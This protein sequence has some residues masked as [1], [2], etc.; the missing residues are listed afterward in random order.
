MTW[1][2]QPV[3][4]LAGSK[5]H[6]SELPASYNRGTT[7]IGQAEKKQLMGS[8][9]NVAESTPQGIDSFFFLLTMTFVSQCCMGLEGPSVPW[10]MMHLNNDDM[11]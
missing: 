2:C 3:T 1:N 5:G 10:H 9:K 4:I 8:G 11:I 7:L 6:D